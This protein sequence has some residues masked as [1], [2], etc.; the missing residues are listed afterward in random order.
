MQ[1]F[2]SKVKHF[3]K[4]EKGKDYVVGDVHGCFCLLRQKLYDMGFESR[5]D[6]LFSV[7]DLVDR[8]TNSFQVLEW[9]EYK[10]FHSVRGNHEQMAIDAAEGWYDPSNYISN[11][12]EWFL[13]LSPVDRKIYAEAFSKL[14]LA[15]E[16][17]TD[18]GLVGIVHAEVPTNNWKE[19]GLCNPQ[20]IMWNRGRY[21]NGDTTII[22]NVHKV[23]V[24]HTPIKEDVI[25]GNTHYIDTGAFYTGN[26]TVEEI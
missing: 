7:G 19:I 22:K 4:N 12:G 5:N 23:Y 24:G 9:L 11:G 21:M 8:G 6:R 18:K 25:F 14:P 15:I 2:N 16:I 13:N 1:T 17:E 10:W 26:L 3:K 20:S